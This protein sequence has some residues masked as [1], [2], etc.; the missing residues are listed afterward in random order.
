MIPQPVLQN[1]ARAI[2]KALATDPATQARVQELGQ[3]AYHVRCTLPPFRCTFRFESGQLKILDESVTPQVSIQGNAPALVRL[4]AS[5]SGNGGSGYSQGVDISGDAGALLQLSRAMSQL[6][7]DWEELLSQLVGDV[8]ARA[9]TQM[10][11][12]ARHRGAR[13]QAE[14][15]EQLKTLVKSR[16]GLVTREQLEVV[17]R[18]LRELQYRLDRLEARINLNKQGKA[19][20]AV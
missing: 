9:M 15:G 5:A 1:I 6:E 20:R 8:P 16:S 19:N 2:N 4:L 12:L 3:S 11:D 14:Q 13:F 17:S 10:A 18:R 7:I